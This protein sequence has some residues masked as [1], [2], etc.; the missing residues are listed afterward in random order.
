MMIHQTHYINPTL[1]IH[2]LVIKPFQYLMEMTAKIYF[3]ELR[4]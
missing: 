3:I 2:G 1:L 4:A